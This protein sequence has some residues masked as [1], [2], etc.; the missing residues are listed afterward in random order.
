M[1]YPIISNNELPTINP[2]DLTLKEM[3]KYG[4]DEPYQE[5]IKY[6]QKTFSDNVIPVGTILYHGSNEHNLNFNELKKDR[7]TFFGLDF[8]ISIWYILELNGGFR[9]F[10]KYKHGML[11]E[12]KVIEPIPIHLIHRLYDHPNG[13]S[14]CNKEKIACIHPQIG[15]H[16]SSTRTYPPF[17]LGIEVTMN[18]KHF[19]NHIQLIK[20]HVVDVNILRENKY[21]LFNKFDPKKAI[22]ETTKIGGHNKTRKNSIKKN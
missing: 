17:E 21:F 1:I 3:D 10:T 22:L 16:G 8:V 19:K 2:Y 4:W 13:V 5:N 18:M 20:T 11:Y 6:I 9:M 7:I 15:F 12:F 14:I